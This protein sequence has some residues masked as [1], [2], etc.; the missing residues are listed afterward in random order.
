VAVTLT[1]QVTCTHVVVI[2]IHTL[3]DATVVVVT[4]WLYR[5]A[6]MTTCALIDGPI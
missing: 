1:S 2:S 5:E 4:R 6:A 3:I